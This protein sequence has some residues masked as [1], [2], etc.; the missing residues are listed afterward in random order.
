MVHELGH[1]FR[2]GDEYLSGT[3]VFSGVE[4]EVPEP[5]V[6]TQ[7]A[8]SQGGRFDSKS[9]KWNWDRIEAARVLKAP[10]TAVGVREYDA[11]VETG[12]GA[13]L[14]V[15]DVVVLRARRWRSP[16]AFMPRPAPT[17]E[18]EAV[19]GSTL[20]LKDLATIGAIDWD[21]FGAGSVLYRP[22][23]AEASVRSPTNLYARMISP[24]VERY[25]DQN[26]A[27]LSKWPSDPKQNSIDF[28]TYEGM[29]LPT[30]VNFGGISG[31]WSHRHD[32]RIVGIYEGGNEYA[33]GLFHATGMCRMRMGLSTFTSF[34]A[35]CR[36]ALVDFIDPT[37]HGENDARYADEYP[38]G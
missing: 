35:V 19:N 24:Y 1:C 38:G 23:P 32:A 3:A 6:T 22:V 34:C 36:Y 28:K 15:G 12:S 20:R 9:I 17:F 29:Q 18:I 4:A 14:S 8:A 25:I 7:A 2:I 33:G 21:E 10:L 37:K 13:A 30:N 31:S 11:N 27:P 26:N 5:N 16:I